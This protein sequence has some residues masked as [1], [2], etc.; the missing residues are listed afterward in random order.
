[1][2][3]VDVRT[4]PTISVLGNGTM[5]VL[6]GPRFNT[7]DGVETPLLSSGLISSTTVGQV[8]VDGG[9]TARDA[10]NGDVSPLLVLTVGDPRPG[11]TPPT[12]SGHAITLDTSR[13]TAA[14]A[15]VI[16]NYTLPANSVPEVYVDFF[17]TRQLSVVCQPGF[18]SCA[19]PSPSAPSGA[20]LCQL[21]SACSL[22]VPLAQNLTA[23]LPG[24]LTVPAPALPTITLLGPARTV[25]NAGSAYV[26]C[27]ANTPLDSNVTCDHGATASDPIDGDLTNLI[28]ACGSGSPGV[29]GSSTALQARFAAV[30]IS[31]CHLPP[32]TPG[33]YNV[34]FSVTNSRGLTASVIRTVVIQGACIGPTMSVDCNL[35][36][37]LTSELKKQRRT[38][39]PGLATPATPRRHQEGTKC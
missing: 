4:L 36:A 37:C 8:Y 32:G 19:D 24:A 13:P 5:Y 7:T 34:T 20:L 1:V 23:A 12:V 35:N 21:P 22:G 38:C 16:I 10:H 6:V 18:V 15:P 39:I 27:P 2:I 31:A 14:S 28:E 33:I 26:A 25:S 30:G 29:V 9:A 17:A 3:V 11:V